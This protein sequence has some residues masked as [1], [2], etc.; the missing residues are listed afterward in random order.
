[1]SLAPSVAE[2]LKE[3]VLFELEGIDRMYLNL[4]VPQLQREAGIWRFFSEHRGKPIVTSALMGPMTESFVGAI[5]EFVQRHEIAVVEFVKGERKD[6][7]AKKMF[8]HFS[9][10]EGVV[11]VGKAQEKAAVFRTAK[12][13]SQTG[14]SSPSLYRSTAMVNHYYFYCLD[15]D[16]GPFFMKF[17]S[18]FPYNGKVCLNG[19]EYVKRQMEAR[20]IGFEALDNGVLSCEQPSRAQAIGDALSAGKIDRFIRKWFRQL[21]HPFTSNDRRAAYRYDISILQAEFSLTQTLDRPVT[22]RMFFEQVIRENLDLGRP[23]QVQLIFS[24]GVRKTTPGRFRTR[25]ITNGVIPSLHIDYKQS[26][27]KQYHKLG[28]A[29]RTE[30]TINDAHD[31]G[32]GKRLINLPALREIGFSANR[33]L[34]AVQRVSHD[35]SIAEDTLRE[36]V[37]PIQVLTQRASALRFDDPR[38]QALFHVLLLF[39]LQSRG[40]SNKEMRELLAPLLGLEPAQLSAGRMSYDLRRLRLHGI[41]QRLSREHRYRLTPAGLRIALFFS[42]TYARILRPG[43]ATLFAPQHTV[44]SPLR[45]AFNALDRQIQNLCEEARLLA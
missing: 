13:R 29:L 8:A 7:I 39:S 42:R 45:T 32:I 2:I 11:F 4:Y 40:F 36:V 19:H 25:V 20:G 37:R 22:G 6:D 1:M 26:R 17:C 30:T 43:L 9:G 15:A 12:R 5:E 41:I 34:L 21:P 33:R 44:R 10:S 27:I 3:H 23:D 38:V 14:R 16:F 35:C 31:F 24:R 18:Y 28:R